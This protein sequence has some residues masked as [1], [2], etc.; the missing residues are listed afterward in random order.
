MGNIFFRRFTRT[1]RKHEKNIAKNMGDDILKQGHLVSGPPGNHII[2]K[3]K[4]WTSIVGTSSYP[5]V[6]CGS[7]STHFQDLPSSTLR[8]MFPKIGGFYPQNGWFIMENPIKWMIWGYHYFW[9]HPEKHLAIPKTVQLSPW[10]PQILSPAAL[11]DLADLKDLR[12]G[13]VADGTFFWQFCTTTWFERL[14][15]FVN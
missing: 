6:K 5:L 13:S 10:T 8:R 15:F 2:K 4:G 1:E 11:Q 14:F 12:L 9:K 3:H 7:T